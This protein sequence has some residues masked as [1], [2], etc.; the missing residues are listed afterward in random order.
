MKFKINFIKKWK[1]LPLN[2]DKDLKPFAKREKP[3]TWK[4]VFF[5]DKISVVNTIMLLIGLL[6]ILIIKS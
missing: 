3:L 2:A 1:E 6:L 4:Q 5:R